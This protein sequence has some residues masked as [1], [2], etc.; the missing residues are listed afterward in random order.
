MDFKGFCRSLGIL[1]RGKISDLSNKQLLEQP[2]AFEVQRIS[3]IQHRYPQLRMTNHG[4]DWYQELLNIL[5]VTYNNG[6]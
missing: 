3:L 4:P 6:R 2:S 1:K 5:Y